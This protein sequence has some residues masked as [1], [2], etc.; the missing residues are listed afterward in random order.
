MNIEE[1]PPLSPPLAPPT[2]PPAATLAPPLAPPAPPTTHARLPVRSFAGWAKASQILVGATAAVGLGELVLASQYL[3]A[4]SGWEDGTRNFD[5][6]I[7]AEESFLAS[8]PLHLVLLLAASVVT[9]TWLYRMAKNTES[10]RLAPLEHTPKWAVWGWV[11]PIL[12]LFRPYQMIGQTWRASAS[13]TQTY[14]QL[15]RLAP[16]W[17]GTFLLTLAL[18]Q[19]SASATSVEWT[20]DNA[21]LMLQT[22]RMAS[23]AD[24]VSAVL[25]ILIVRALTQRQADTITELEAPQGLNPTN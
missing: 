11:V 5:D 15:T 18:D 14:E 9:V 21:R 13:P 4:L 8:G 24:A 23:V 6:L 16:W 20:P 3:S 17:W 25:F 12:S 22:A 2:A 1:P 19:I 10:L 7:D